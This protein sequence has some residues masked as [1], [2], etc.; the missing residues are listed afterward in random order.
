MSEPK[1]PPLNGLREK[2]LFRQIIQ[3]E[4][5][6]LIGVSQSHYR[7]IETG[8]VRLDIHRAAKLAKHLEC[9]VEELL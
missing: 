1:N 5:A 7:Q 4:L 2:R 6:D 3:Q 9:H 8:G